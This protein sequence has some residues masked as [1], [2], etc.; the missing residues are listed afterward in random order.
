M[1]FLMSP[2]L[3]YPLWVWL[4]FLLGVLALLA[5]DL[6]VL[7]KDGREIGVKDSLRLSAF[8]IG[9]GLLFGG[10]VWW[11]RGADAG[12]QYFTGYLLE[13]SLSLDNVFVISLIFSSMA[14]PRVYQHR[15]LFWGI[16][17]AIAMRALMIGAGAALV[18]QFQWVLLLFG[19]FLLA[20]GLK[21]LLSADDEAKPLSE[22][23]FYQWLRRHMRLT[24]ALHGNAFL[25]RGETHGMARGWW[26]TPL[27][28]T[29]I[30]VES[31]DLV[32]AVDSIPAIFAVTQ[33]PFLVYTS[34]I[35]A[36]LGLRALYFALSAMVH[37][38]HYLKYALAL[39]LVLI[40]V[41]VGLVYLHDAGL[42]AFKIPTL[43]SLLLTVLL[44][45]G[46]IAY[47]WHKTRRVPPG[48]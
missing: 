20:A 14:V 47:S 19:V 22:Q 27:L 44:L 15:V 5:F 18:A 10:W 41:K 39:V 46:G 3:G 9:I 4:M 29:L 26:A 2:A 34:N 28:L 11:Y 45:S 31:A 35:F 6:G 32:F 36:I 7:Q 23:R 42:V 24:P 17:G 16:L 30:L 21:M 13:K 12:V 1:E 37:R 8:Y 40:G 33:D 38:F 48:S 43:L 25:L